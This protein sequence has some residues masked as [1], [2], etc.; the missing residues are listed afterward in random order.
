[1]KRSYRSLARRFADAEPQ[2]LLDLFKHLENQLEDLDEAQREKVETELVDF[3][4]N[5]LCDEF[6]LA[7]LLENALEVDEEEEAS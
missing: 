1:M 4:Q 2:T 5:A 7:N 6:G 3:L